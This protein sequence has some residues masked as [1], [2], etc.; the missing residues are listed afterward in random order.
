VFAFT[1]LAGHDESPFVSLNTD[2]LSTGTIVTDL[3]AVGLVASSLA[4]RP[5]PEVHGEFDGDPMYTVLPPDAIPAIHEPQYVTGEQAAAQMS[6][7]E[8]VMGLA[9]GDDPVCW[10]TWQLDHHEIVNDVVAGIP[11]AAT[12]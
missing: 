4:Q 7:D 12:W 2:S 11:L 10:S 9:I 8:L 6:A 3:L 5:E 1:L